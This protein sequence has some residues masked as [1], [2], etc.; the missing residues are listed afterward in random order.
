M[1]VQQ[2]LRVPDDILIRLLQT[3]S[4]SRHFTT[5]R[6]AWQIYREGIGR[7][8]VFHSDV[9]SD[10]LP[11]FL[12]AL[13]GPLS[14]LALRALAPADDSIRS[15]FI[16]QLKEDL[17][18]PTII[19][20]CSAPRLTSLCLSFDSSYSKLL[21]RET[22]GPADDLPAALSSLSRPTSLRSLR[23][24]WIITTLPGR[25]SSHTPRNAPR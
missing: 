22:A 6:S 21:R 2:V 12:A 10:Q 8:A 15:L 19:S 17:A 3:H 13:P 20:A 5:S 11:L 25:P 16:T 4:A 7:V 23:V 1:Q 18:V 9:R 14:L 24:F